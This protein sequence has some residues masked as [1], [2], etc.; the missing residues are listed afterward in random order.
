MGLPPFRKIITAIIIIVA[1]TSSNNANAKIE[2]I[3]ATNCD[4][5]IAFNNNYYN[6][7]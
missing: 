5:N 2:I 4:N 6:P 3:K 1:M 7:N